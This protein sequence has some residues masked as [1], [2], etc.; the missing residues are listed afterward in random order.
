M[1]FEPGL[2][3]VIDQHAA[4]VRD[5][6]GGSTLIISRG[7]PVPRALGAD[8]DCNR[9]VPPLTAFCAAKSCRTRCRIRAGG[10]R[11]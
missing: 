4:A 10:L 2:V 3:A 5:V 8:T 1:A 9:V 6:L 7:A 11:S